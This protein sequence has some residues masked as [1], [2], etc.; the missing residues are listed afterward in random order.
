MFKLAESRS[1][2]WKSASSESWTGRME[3]FISFIYFPFSLPFLPSLPFMSCPLILLFPLPFLWPKRKRPTDKYIF[4]FVHNV[5]FFLFFSI[6]FSSISSIFFLLLF[7]LHSHCNII[8]SIPKVS[9]C[10]GKIQIFILA[11][12]WL[13]LM[14]GFVTSGFFSHFHTVSPIDALLC[15]PAV[16]ASPFPCRCKTSQLK[17]IDIIWRVNWQVDASRNYRQYHR[18][19][20]G[21]RTMR[22]AFGLGGMDSDGIC[23]GLEILRTVVLCDS[24]MKWKKWQNYPS[25]TIKL[26][27]EQK[28]RFFQHN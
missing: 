28:S 7:S 13:L 26:S 17:V 1:V 12:F 22:T 8:D 10:F 11:Q 23:S 3:T 2:S 4:L 25:T 27:P 24:V 14:D 20:R 15:Y 6:L 5:F 16:G 18:S 9:C 19:H 21:V